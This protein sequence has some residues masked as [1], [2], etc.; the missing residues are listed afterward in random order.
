L[1][2]DQRRSFKL[3]RLEEALRLIEG[4]LK[5]K[6]L[7]SEV[8][9]SKDSLG[10]VLA[11]DIVSDRKLPD[12]DYA[13]LDGYALRTAD[14][15]SASEGTQVALKVM[16]E[17]FPTDHPTEATIGRGE[18]MYVACGA[19]IPKG[20][21]VVVRVE[22]VALR[23]GEIVVKQPLEPGR[24]ICQEGEDVEAG[25]LILKRG[26]V[27]RPQDI[28]LLIALNRE[29]IKVVR[30]PRVA[31]LS[32]GDELTEPFKDARDKV[33]NNNAYIV[34]GLIEHFNATPI[35]MGIVGDDVK[36]I[37]ERLTSALKLADVALTIAGCSVGVRDYVPDAV[38]SLGP[39]GL[40]FHGVALS[41]GKV[42]G[43]GAAGCKPIVM[44]PGHVGSTVAAFYLLTLPILNMLQGLGFNDHLP[45]VR[46]MLDDPVKAKPYVDLVLPVKLY[47]DGGVY[48]AVP[49]RKPLTVLKS[50]ADANGYTLIP[51]GVAVNRGEYVDVKLFGG[52]EFPMI[53]GGE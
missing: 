50:L 4:F 26:R 17:L 38:E 48:H 47:R 3:I 21:D 36:E 29:Y 10:R 13:A 31:V 28:G 11:E 25:S 30:R 5:D 22:E 40:I 12:Y 14:I 24:N 8:I 52:L 27:I 51:A 18:A 35:P 41:A 39:P 42:S 44:L 7:G 53:Q 2:S 15:E 19:P 33:V 46:C 9:H 16:G 34:S 37:A 43:F 23:D 6:T 32:V 1:R 20:G 45:T 49:M